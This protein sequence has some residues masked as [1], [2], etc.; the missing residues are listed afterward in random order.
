MDLIMFKITNWKDLQ[1]LPIS[2]TL[3]NQLKQH[4]L[5]PFHDENEAL[6]TWTELECELWMITSLLDI[7]RFGVDC[8]CITQR[9]HDLL[10]FALENVEFEDKLDSNTLLTLTILNSSG[11]GLYLLMPWSLKAELIKELNLDKP[12]HG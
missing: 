12:T 3:Q 9:E 7:S 11:Q 5:V 4:L 6:S 1:T 2:P 10:S 8:K